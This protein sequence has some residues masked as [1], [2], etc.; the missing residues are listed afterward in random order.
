M[1]NK[2]N[3]RKSGIPCRESQKVV[4][5]MTYSP[6]PDYH[7]LAEWQMAE[8]V[9]NLLRKTCDELN[10]APDREWLLEVIRENADNLTQSIAEGQS[11]EYAA[12]YLLG[13]G[14]ARNSVV[15]V[16]YCFRFLRGENLIDDSL[17]DSVEERLED[18]DSALEALA[19]ELRR[20]LPNQWRY[21]NN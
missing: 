12:E 11:S 16:S 7:E 20:S 18:L 21:S 14:S 3:E 19:Q 4:D 2:R 10:L 9:A 6:R 13:V 15:M 1:R 17:A 8:S 5:T